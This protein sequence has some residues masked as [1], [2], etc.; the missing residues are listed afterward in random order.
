MAVGGL[1]M[2]GSLGNKYSVGI[3]NIMQ[4]WVGGYPWGLYNHEVGP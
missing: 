3:I 4:S 2:V 1:T